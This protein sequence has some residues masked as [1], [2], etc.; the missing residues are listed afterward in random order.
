MPNIPLKVPLSVDS[1][2]LD[3]R[4]IIYQRFQHWRNIRNIILKVEEQVYPEHLEQRI[5]SELV[6]LLLEGNTTKAL[7]LYDVIETLRKRYLLSNIGS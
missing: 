7:A 3:T 5:K 4:S 6:P 1:I 2:W